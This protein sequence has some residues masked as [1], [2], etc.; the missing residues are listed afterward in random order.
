M[1]TSTVG[2]WDSLSPTAR[3]AVEDIIEILADKTFTGR[4]TL[5]I[6]QGGVREMTHTVILR[7]PDLTQDG[8]RPGAAADDERAGE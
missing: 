6:G 2:A 4:I 5:E 7:G 1:Q 8:R 3:A